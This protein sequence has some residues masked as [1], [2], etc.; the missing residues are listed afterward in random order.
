[1]YTLAGSLALEVDGLE[2]PRPKPK[3][4]VPNSS[5]S[6]SSLSNRPP[7][8]ATGF[9]FPVGPLLAVFCITC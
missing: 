5:S 1:M 7:S 2:D 8:L 6:S 4:D 3:F 9:F